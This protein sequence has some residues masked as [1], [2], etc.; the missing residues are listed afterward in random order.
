MERFCKRPR[1]RAGQLEPPVRRDP[2]PDAGQGRPRDPDPAPRRSTACPIPTPPAARPPRKGWPKALQQSSPTL[3]LAL[4]TLAF[5]KQVE[6]RWRNYSDPALP[7]HLANEVDPEAV[8]AMEEAVVERY[9]RLSHRYYALKAKALGKTALDYWDTQRPP[10]PGPAAPIRLGRGQGPGA[11]VV[12]RAGPRLRRP[13]PDLLRPAVD[14]RAPPRGKSSG[15]YSHPGHVRQAPLCVHELHG[16][17]PRRPDPGPR[18]RPRRAP[19]P[20][21]S[22]RHASRR[23]P[24]HLG[25]NGLDLRR[26]AWCSS[27]C[28]RRR[29]RPTAR[30]CWPARSRTGSTPWS[31][32]SPSTASRTRF[33]AGPRRR[34]AV[35]RP[36][37]R[38]VAGGDGRKPGPRGAA[39]P[40]L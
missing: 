40:G 11:V 33:H 2:Q 20:G 14:R 29:P 32:R 25:R 7:R 17:A 34:R 24:A 30:P 16:R 37:R 27:A 31:A 39:E 35:A 26:R 5:E 12:P 15:A 38:L 13:R 4:N 10:R 19:D 9:P 22:P 23:H 28:W 18:A 21:L 6:D 36:H 3:A 1:P 8:Q